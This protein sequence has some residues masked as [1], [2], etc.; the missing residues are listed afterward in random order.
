M[1]Y[2]ES[3]FFLKLIVTLLVKKSAFRNPMARWHIYSLLSEHILKKIKPVYILFLGLDLILS[4]RSY[5]SYASFFHSGLE[6]NI[7]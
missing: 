7:R 4:S 3:R 6:Q 2:V 1:D 5:V